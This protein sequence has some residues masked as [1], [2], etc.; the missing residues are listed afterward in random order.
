MNQQNEIDSGLDPVKSERD[1][2]SGNF[3]TG[4]ESF[5]GVFTQTQVYLSSVRL[6]HDGKV[7]QPIS[8]LASQIE[9]NRRRFLHSGDVTF[10]LQELMR[11]TSSYNHRVQAWESEASQ[12]EGDKKTMSGGALA[13]MKSELSMVRTKTRL[14][15][16]TLT[17]LEVELHQIAGRETMEAKQQRSGTGNNS[18]SGIAEKS[19]SEPAIE[20]QK[21]VLTI[22]EQAQAAECIRD[23]NLFLQNVVGKSLLVSYENADREITGDPDRIEQVWDTQLDSKLPIVLVAGWTV[24]H[25]NNPDVMSQERKKLD[26]SFW[27]IPKSLNVSNELRR[28]DGQTGLWISSRKL[29]SARIMFRIAADNES[30]KSDLMLGFL[31]KFTSK[32]GDQPPTLLVAQFHNLEWTQKTV[33]ASCLEQQ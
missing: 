24:K 23:I 12:R 1:D 30:P 22:A 32:Y 19:A 4:S 28:V 2:A 3:Y 29:D 33:V 21:P 16:R 18:Q 11:I 31:D 15:S 27:L 7:T 13:K 25:P 17:K 14:A 5:F 9:N 20:K 26:L 10:A 6:V 8:D